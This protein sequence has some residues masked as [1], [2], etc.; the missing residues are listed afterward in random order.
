MT[1]TLLH[2]VGA[3][4]LMLS[5]AQPDPGAQ[6]CSALRHPCLFSGF[7]LPLPW[8]YLPNS[9]GGEGAWNKAFADPH[10]SI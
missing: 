3:R 5:W 7:I 6:A 4:A 10:A 1:P 9:Q 2:G 8:G